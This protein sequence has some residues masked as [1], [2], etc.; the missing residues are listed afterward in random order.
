MPQ[1]RL[2]GGSHTLVQTKSHTIGEDILGDGGI[3][4]RKIRN[5]TSDA[6]PKT[7]DFVYIHYRC[8]N[9]SSTVP[10]DDSRTNDERNNE[11]FGFL[12]GRGDVMK[13]WE[14]AV[15]TM[16]AG[17]V[18]LFFIRNEYTFAADG[19]R[20]KG[21]F[22]LASPNHAKAVPH[23][24]DILCEIE[25]VEFGR[26]RSCTKDRKV[27]LFE[28][29]DRAPL[30]TFDRPKFQ[31]IDEVELKLSVSVAGEKLIEHEEVPARY[32]FG[33]GVLPPGLELVINEYLFPNVTTRLHLVD[34]WG[35]NC[36][37][38]R[39]MSSTRR[40]LMPTA[41]MSDTSSAVVMD[42]NVTLVDWN[43]RY[44][45]D[46]LPSGWI[47]CVGLQARM[48]SAASLE[49]AQWRWDS[50]WTGQLYDEII[51]DGTETIL[52]FRMRAIKNSSHV[53]LYQRK[54]VECEIGD[55]R[56]P[57]AVEMSLPRLK[58]GQRGTISFSKASGLYRC[59]DAE[60]E[61]ESLLETASDMAMIEFD[62]IVH[63]AVKSM[64]ASNLTKKLLMANERKLIGN[65]FFKLG[66]TFA[67]ENKYN[68]AMLHLNFEELENSDE[69]LDATTYEV[70]AIED[71]EKKE[72]MEAQGNVY[73]NLAACQRRLGNPNLAVKFCDL[74]L[75]IS[76]R[77]SQQLRCKANRWK[78]LA[79]LEDDKYELAKKAAEKA[80]EIDPDNEEVLSM[81]RRV[82]AH[83]N[84]L[85]KR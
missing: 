77:L 84:E 56:L 38:F 58:V 62:V 83:H 12:L 17:E 28:L 67:A 61:L 74:T 5:S 42:V 16:K 23:D 51:D 31:Y 70:S 15:S 3:I 65:R 13:A 53:I 19:S 25:L 73:L 37:L 21:L 14:I 39:N 32:P 18:S 85:M 44:P 82:V 40:D 41:D 8:Y 46:D 81:Q 47:K 52:S 43:T 4:K 48:W 59:R 10:F 55:G 30:P 49:E 22:S 68:A 75:D 20:L 66:L 54:F 11:P 33:R 9:A 36:S 78:A 50:H 27:R 6:S 34:E 1:M 71:A 64:A 80:A 72:L 7:D 63:A 26:G 76:P 24:A 29:A 45:V 60:E 2:R 69:I 57:A 35:L 79:L